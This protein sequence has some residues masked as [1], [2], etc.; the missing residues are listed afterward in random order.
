MKGVTA[1]KTRYAGDR[2]LCKECYDVKTRDPSGICS[3]CR[4]NEPHGPDQIVAKY[5]AQTYVPY[6][7]AFYTEE[8]PCKGRNEFLLPNASQRVRD[9]CR[10]CPIYDWCL[11]WGI[12]NDEQGIWGGLS[13]LERKIVREGKPGLTPERYE[14][15]A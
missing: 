11:E 8:L 3:A 2:V 12:A 6:P 4:G 14:L 5:E 10:R 9:M 15:V 13:R 1:V 7:E